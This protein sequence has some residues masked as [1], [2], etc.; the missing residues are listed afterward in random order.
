ML[1]L[2]LNHV[3]KGASGVNSLFFRKLTML[4]GDYIVL[5]LPVTSWQGIAC[6]NPWIDLTVDL[7]YQ[8]TD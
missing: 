1:G 4:Q 2:K 6:A 5:W 8:V 3:S 7:I